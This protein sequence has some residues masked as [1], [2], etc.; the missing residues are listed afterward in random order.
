M[1]Y[2]VGAGPVG[3]YAAYLLSK[4]GKEV[5]VFEEHSAIGSPIQCTGLLTPSINKTIK[6][7]K[8]VVINKIKKAR[9]C[10][11]KNFFETGMTDI[12]IDRK[13][14]D[15]S[16]ANKATKKGS[17]FFLGHKFIEINKKQII[18]KNLKTKKLKKVDFSQD[19]ILIGA[20]GPNS[21]VRNYVDKKNKISHWVGIQARAKLKTS[22]DTFEVWFDK[23][24]GFFG[25]VVPENKQTIRIGLAAKKNTSTYFRKLLDSKGIKQK[26]IIELQGGLIPIYNP[27]LNVQKEN[28]YLVGDAAAQVKAT[29]GG[30]IIPGL[31]AAECLADSIL[32]N[33]DYHRQLRRRLNLKLSS[34]LR[35]RKILDKFSEKDID[36]LIRFCSQDKIKK[37][38]RN[39]D[40]D[41]PIKLL[42]LLAAKEPRFMLF[43]RKLL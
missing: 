32:H 1:I 38:L 7:E 2:I 9:I 30:G 20:D 3:C 24:P 25:W 12:V 43:A 13:R 39:T 21:A 8:G 28:I 14:F 16:L 18:L 35:L 42:L 33:K 5:M 34:H 6:L 11:N 29:T 17:E 31:I 15:Q 36:T 41:N 19:D 10:N 40:R 26:D 37:L 23:A 4:A 27:K 22:G